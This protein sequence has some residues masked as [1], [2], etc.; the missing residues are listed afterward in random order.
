MAIRYAVDLTDTERGVVQE[1]LSKNK[2]KRSTIIN[3]YI[4]LK[5]DRT[6][7]WTN[8]DIALAYEVSTKK[9]EQRKKRFVEEGFEAALYRKPVT[10]V[11]RRKITGDEEAHLIALYCSQAPEGHERWTLRLLADTMVEL[12]IVDSV[13]HE[14]IR[15]TLKK[16]NLNPGKRKNGAFPPS[17]TPPL[18]VRW[19][20]S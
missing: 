20:K 5:A 16:T 10:N 6:C 2:A 12:D 4:L 14:T 9:V 15:R 8:A 11:H 13:S 1:I 18:S 19:K 7:G 17:K 3:A